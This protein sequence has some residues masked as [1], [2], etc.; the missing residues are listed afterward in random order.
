M[1]ARPSKNSC[2]PKGNYAL[3]VLGLGIFLE[4]MYKWDRAKPRN[5]SLCTTYFKCIL[6]SVQHLNYK[7]GIQR[8]W[9]HNALISVELMA[10]SMD[11]G[12]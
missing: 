10:L 12:T 8:A 3:V 6:E 7:V 5:Y 1:L 2:Y 11:S 9:G 4:S